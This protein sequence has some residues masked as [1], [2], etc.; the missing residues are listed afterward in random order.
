MTMWM[1]ATVAVL[2]AWVGAIIN[3]ASLPSKTWLVIELVLGRLGLPFVV[4][5]YVVGRPEATA[6]DRRRPGTTG[7]RLG[8]RNR[9]GPTDDQR[10]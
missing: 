6:Y 2:V 9:P 8:R 4:L 7:G 5:A 10:V 1:A 3:T